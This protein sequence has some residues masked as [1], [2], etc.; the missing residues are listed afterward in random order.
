MNRWKQLL[1]LAAPAAAVALSAASRPA[2]LAQVNGGLWELTGSQFKQPLRQCV[3]DSMLL[4]Q[5]EHR[6][7]NCSRTV[8][9]DGESQT[10]IEYKCAGGGFGRS[11]ISVI[12]P[13]ALTIETQGI[14]DNFP[15]G[16]RLEAHRIGD[17]GGQA[18]I[19]AH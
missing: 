3:A 6:G 2:A 9:T 11:K 10:V 16:Y 8:I 18:G 5:V 17:C 14:S 4:A 13:R 1:I 19:P 7:K 15:F 12:T